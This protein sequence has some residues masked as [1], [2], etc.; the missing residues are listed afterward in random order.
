MLDAVAALTRAEIAQERPAR[1]AALE[2]LAVA[3]V[4]PTAR[5]EPAVRT[6]ARVYARDGYQ[7]RYC[8]GK[9]VLTPVMRLLSRLHPEAFPYQVNWKAGLTHPA[10]A[11][12]SATLDH[13]VP[14]ALGGDSLA[15]DNL[16]CACWSCN[17]RK[18]DLT[19]DA[20]GFMLTDRP[21]D[22]A[23]DGLSASYRA[24]WVAAGQ[25]MLGANER[26]WMRAVDATTASPAVAPKVIG[27]H[28]RT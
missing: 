22:P 21:A 13:V 24:L 25:P 20:V 17:L 19:M 18:S 2:L 3:P 23:W 16:V 11:A 5:R 8:G 1:A 6:V 15:E 26:E 7:C 28:G 10:F 4:I 27:L 9:V 12:L 14:V